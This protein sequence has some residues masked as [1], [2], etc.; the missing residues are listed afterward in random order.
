MIDT[1]FR[2]VGGRISVLLSGRVLFGTVGVFDVTC[3]PT[4]T[5]R[6]IV[7]VGTRDLVVLLFQ[8]AVQFLLAVG[9]MEINRTNICL[10]V[11]LKPNIPYL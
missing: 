6:N 2:R 3:H 11:E 1:P 10:T 5:G 9:L 4:L 8:M 7:A